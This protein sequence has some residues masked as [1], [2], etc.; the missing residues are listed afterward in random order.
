MHRV[1]NDIIAAITGTKGIFLSRLVFVNNGTGSKEIYICDF[2]GQNVERLTSFKSISLLPRWSP[3]GDKIVF[4]SYKDG[5][6]MLYIMDI[7]TKNTRLLSGRDGLNIGGGSWLPEGDR[8]AVTSRKNGNPD[9]FIITTDGKISEQLT[10]YW[11]IDI[12]PT[13]S[14]DGTR[15]A[16][17]SNRSGEPQIYVKD[18]KSGN[19]ERITFDLKYCTSPVWSNSNRIAFA[20]MQDNKVDIYSINPDGSNMKKL[21]DSSGNNEDPCWSPDG[22]YI[23]FSSNRDGGAYHLYMMNSNGENQRRITSQKGEDTAPNWSP[24]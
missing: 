1:A 24:F 11:G 17:V 9:I 4:N 18:L 23:V 19:E 14:P 22:R 16:Y 2:D 3:S 13:F 15:M 8:L 10:D 6:S 7:S 5:G 20:V 12:S 21:T